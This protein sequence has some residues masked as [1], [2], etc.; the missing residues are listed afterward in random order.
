MKIIPH[1]GAGPIRFGMTRSEVEQAI[2]R[3]PIR[4]RR[5][6][7]EQS[8]HDYFEA[9]GLFVYYDQE[10]KCNAAELTCESDA[11]YEG[12][13]LFAVPAIHVREW[14]RQRDANIESKDGFVS[15]LLGLSMYA[16]MID[17]R[18]LEEGERNAPAQSFLVFKPESY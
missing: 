10:D 7:F 1:C 11:E 13:Q 2:G 6:E 17:E 14:A 4:R 16:P 3:T 9:R 18:D 8:V 5:N 15:R 12:I